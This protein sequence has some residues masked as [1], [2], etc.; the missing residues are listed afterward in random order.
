[1]TVKKAQCKASNRLHSNDV[2]HNDRQ[3]NDVQHKDVQRKTPSS[4]AMAPVMPDDDASKAPPQRAVSA[5]PLSPEIPAPHAENLFERV[6]HAVARRIGHQDPTHPQPHGILTHERVLHSGTA[7]VGI[8]E[9]GYTLSELNLVRRAEGVEVIQAV[10]EDGSANLEL[11]LGRFQPVWLAKILHGAGR[12]EVQGPA[13]NTSL[14]GGQAPVGFRLFG[15]ALTGDKGTPYSSDAISYTLEL[16][17]TDKSVA[18]AAALFGPGIADEILSTLGD[19]GAV[20]IGHAVAD[21]FAGAV[22]VVSAAI[23]AVSVHR[24]VK[25]CQDP[26][27]DAEKRAFVVAHAVGDVV[28]VILPVPGTIMNVTLVIAATARTAQK[29]HQVHHQQAQHRPVQTASL[30][31]APGPGS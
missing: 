30:E 19:S 4:R 10:N 21:V 8:A 26:S 7:L 16:K 15:F 24:A 22:P 6:V 27:A 31:K 25:V 29:L 3:R 17:L 23:A 1:M 13:L 28:R 11:V 9:V 12:L 18:A 14:S 2:Q 5:L 20:S